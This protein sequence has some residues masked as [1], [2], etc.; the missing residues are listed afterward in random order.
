MVNPYATDSAAEKAPAPMSCDNCGGVKF[1]RVKPLATF[2]FAKDFQCVECREQIPAPV[3][4]WGSITMLVPGTLLFLLG[5][6][7]AVSTAF[8][9]FN[10][11]V[12]LGTVLAIFGLKFAIAGLNS[13]IG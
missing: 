12:V 7:Y 2:A 3:P 5:V 6:F 4:A 1:N 11:G 13:L 8:G 9:G 10:I